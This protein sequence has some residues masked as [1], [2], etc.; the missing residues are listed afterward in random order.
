MHLA[1]HAAADALCDVQSSKQEQYMHICIMYSTTQGMHS[2]MYSN[3]SYITLRPDDVV[4]SQI[5]NRKSF[6]WY[7]LRWV[8]PE[9]QRPVH[10][11]N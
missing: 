10:K 11:D 9:P 2:G 5:V 4:G 8:E 7:L 1:A 6:F 3:I